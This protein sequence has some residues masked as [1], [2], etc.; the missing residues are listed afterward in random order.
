MH[1]VLVCALSFSKNQRHRI[2]TVRAGRVYAICELER[3]NI[4]L[5]RMREKG[6]GSENNNSEVTILI[7]PFI[8][9]S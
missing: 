8:K 3:P 9:I 2:S 1:C 6:G 5:V 4:S 7:Y